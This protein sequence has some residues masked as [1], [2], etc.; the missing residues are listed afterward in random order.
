[1]R[2]W[3]REMLSV[4]HKEPKRGRSRSE[5]RNHVWSWGLAFNRM[6]GGR[7]LK[8]MVMINE[9]TRECLAIHVAQRIRGDDAID[10][11]ANLM[12]GPGTPEHP[13]RKRPGNG[14]H[15]LE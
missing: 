5:R 9:Y 7:P 13:F 6:D 1:M 8:L 11:V 10:V 12:V 3:Q 14:R 15:V 4:P 2:I